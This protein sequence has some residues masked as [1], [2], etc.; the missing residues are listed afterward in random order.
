MSHGSGTD[1]DLGFFEMPQLDARL[2]AFTVLGVVEPVK[3]NVRFADPHLTPSVDSDS[4]LNI[5]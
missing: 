4:N 3:R 2:V 1:V 5:C